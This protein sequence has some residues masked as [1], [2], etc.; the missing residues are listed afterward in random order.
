MQHIHHPINEC[1]N[2][3]INIKRNFKEDFHHL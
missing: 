2:N 1:G 3:L